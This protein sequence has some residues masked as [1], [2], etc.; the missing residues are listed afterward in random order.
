MTPIE[1]SD[2]GN[3]TGNA[4]ENAEGKDAKKGAGNGVVD[5]FLLAP[6]DKSFFVWQKTA[7]E[8]KECNQTN[9]R[10]AQKHPKG[11]ML[12][13]KKQIAAYMTR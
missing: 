2:A 3:A 9:L 7:S 5:A 13:D 1:G 11:Q 8:F 4:D 12:K 10:K 6:K